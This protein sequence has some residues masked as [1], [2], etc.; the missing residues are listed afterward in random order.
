M[1][2]GDHTLYLDHETPDAIISVL[3]GDSELS[4]RKNIRDFLDGGGRV[5]VYNGEWDFMCNWIG[6]H[7][8][9]SQMVWSGQ[10]AFNAA[11][12]V[13]WH[14]KKGEVAGWVQGTPDRQLQFIKVAN[15]GHLVPHDQPQNALEMLSRFLSNQTFATL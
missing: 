6:G 3:D 1:G 14:N 2:V 4:F 9:V 12:N 13:T 5:L 15:S 7:R 11:S 10:E 8:W